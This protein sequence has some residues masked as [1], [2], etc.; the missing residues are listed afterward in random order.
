M[1]SDK[2]L[3]FRLNDTALPDWV[4]FWLRAEFGRLEIQR[5]STGNQES[6]RNIGQDRIR[7]IRIKVPSLPEQARIV[8][9]VERRLSMIDELETGV[10]ANLKRAERLRQSIL[11]RAFTG[12]LLGT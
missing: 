1:L 11:R 10:I 9:E 2:I 4:L 12:R 3:R 7:Q 8:A 5:L 6:M